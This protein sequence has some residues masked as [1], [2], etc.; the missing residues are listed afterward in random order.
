M[1]AA[2]A[3]SVA[4][5]ACVA[6][7]ASVDFVRAALGDSALAVDG[8][9]TLSLFPIHKI[10]LP[11]AR[12]RSNKDDQPLAGSIGGV[13]IADDV[14]DCAQHSS[15]RARAR[16][17][18]PEGSELDISEHTQQNDPSADPHCT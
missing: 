18:L 9:V 8:P 2:S 15:R 1:G 14:G 3:A 11:E 7:V 13:R 10:H 16:R 5:V 6:S 17:Q 12:T 4:C